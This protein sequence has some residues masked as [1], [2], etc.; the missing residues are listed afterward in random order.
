MSAY[1]QSY[2]ARCYALLVQSVEFGSYEPTVTGSSPVRSI[3]T[4]ISVYKIKILILYIMPKSRQSQ[5]GARRRKSAAPR[6]RHRK[7]AA[8]RR[9]HRARRHLQS[10]G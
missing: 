4:F 7:S 6:H 10:G 8:A 3:F 1:A 2:S 5:S 9:T